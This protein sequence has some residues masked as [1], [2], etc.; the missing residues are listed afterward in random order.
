MGKKLGLISPQFSF[1]NLKVNGQLQGVYLKSEHWGK[2]FLANHELS[3]D[4]DLYGEAEFI[5]GVSNL[6]SDVKYF[7]KY[8]FDPKKPEDDVS[9]FKTLLEIL[10]QPS[11]EE[12]FNQIPDIIDMDNFLHW[13]AQ[14][15]LAFS[16]SQ[17]Y[18]H[19]LIAYFNPE[20]NK[21]QFIPWNVAMADK[22]PVYPDINY[23]PLMV[24]ILK[25][26][27]YM[28]KRN[29]I[30][31]QY[32]SNPE[33]LT[34][35]LQYFDDLYQS[36]RG[37]FY[38]D[39]LKIFPNLDFDLTVK[40]HRKR[41]ITAQNRIKELLN[42]AQAETKLEPINN[43]TY[44]FTVISQGFSSLKIDSI[45]PQPI[46]ILEAGNQISLKQ[47]LIHTHRNTQTQKDPFLL[48]PTEKN[49]TL[50]FDKSYNQEEISINLKNAI[51]E[52]I[53]DY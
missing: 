53:I 17:K 51:T 21:F 50:I 33:N 14:S 34:D 23:N 41:I 30:I 36:T 26:P 7:Q 24:R 20:I 29:Q 28:L 9:N 31:W 27:E 38:R 43:T 35:D 1:V 8:T 19:N 47:T 45:N 48:I 4:A 52:K 18:S 15:T 25:N 44:N 10:N 32:V 13:Q 46:K 49:F 22:E 40:K 3:P 12:F 39:S 42:D 11:D 5:K 2:T 16:H 37:S 6:Y